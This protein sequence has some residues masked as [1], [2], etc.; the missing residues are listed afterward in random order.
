MAQGTSSASDLDMRAQ[1]FPGIVGDVAH[2]VVARQLT[3]TARP[4]CT[5][6]P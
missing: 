4:L 1:A 3:D 2:L 6:T 5:R